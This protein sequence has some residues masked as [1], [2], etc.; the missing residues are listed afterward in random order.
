MTRTGM[1]SQLT[2]P[3]LAVLALGW[4]LPP[5]GSALASTLLGPV[6]THPRGPARPAT[7]RA[8]VSPGSL[9]RSSSSDGL[10]RRRPF[11]AALWEARH[12][13]VRAR[14]AVRYSRR[15]ED[16]EGIGT[17]REPERL[18][19]M[20]ADRYGYLRRAQDAAY[21]AKELA[22]TPDERYRVAE[23]L[24]RLECEAGRHEA[25]L[26]YARTMIRLRPRSDAARTVLRRAERHNAVR[27]GRQVG[28]RRMRW[29][30]LSYSTL[31]IGVLTWRKRFSSA[32]KPVASR[33]E[34]MPGPAP[35]DGCAWPMVLSR[36]TRS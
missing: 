21:R 1:L 27:R 30:R 9:V 20:A 28:T 31:S 17:P 18:R 7:K 5:F 2:I 32:F 11:E 14:S 22:R 35:G 26:Q 4:T 13:H 19:Q 16:E 8:L 34:R 25:E 3:T 10:A 29:N 15:A 33:L 12:W 24:S 36:K 23:L 6:A